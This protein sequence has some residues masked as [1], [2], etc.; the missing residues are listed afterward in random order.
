MLFLIYVASIVHGALHKG[1]PLSEF[2]SNH[3][4]TQLS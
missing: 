2:S 1:H 3:L 4:I